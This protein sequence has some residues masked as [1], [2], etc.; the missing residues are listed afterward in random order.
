MLTAT[1]RFTFDSMHVLPNHPGKCRRPHGHTYILEVTVVAV[2]TKVAHDL[3]KHQGYFIDFGDL[4]NMIKAV[5]E[6]WDHYDLGNQDEYPT[7]ERL[8]LKLW[9][10]IEKEFCRGEGPCPCDLVTLKLH[11]TPNNWVEYDGHDY[12]FSHI[13]TP[14][15]EVL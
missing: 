10:Q 5:L 9:R 14:P 7:A 2:D 3:W 6:S 11:E 8:I 13:N 12:A 1:R 4:K 15:T